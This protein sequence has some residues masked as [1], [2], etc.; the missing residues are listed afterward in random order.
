MRAVTVLDYGAGNLQTVNRQLKR[1]GAEVIVSSDPDRIA[2]AEKIVLPGVGHFGAAME[3]L[4]KQGHVEALN[5]AVLA[6]GVPVLGICLG[7]QLMASS[8]TEGN[9]RGLGWFQ[10]SVVRLEVPDRL[11]FK[12]P[13]MGWNQVR[14]TRDSALLGD[15]PDLSEFYFLHSY[16]YVPEDTDDVLLTADYCHTFACAIER[17]N[18]YGVQFHPEKSHD[19]GMK[20]LG[21]FLRL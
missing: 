19:V 5:R 6:R 18:I 12:I 4:L 3:N 10:G 11:R 8:S 17:D 7:M 9:S 14:K 13:H 20:L 21:N 2:R 16:C 15:I 1:L